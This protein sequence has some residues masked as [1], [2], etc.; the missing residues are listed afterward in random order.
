MIDTKVELPGIEG[1]KLITLESR[2]R[3]YFKRDGCR[4]MS[5]IAR[6]DLTTVECRECG[7][8]NLSPVDWII[9]MIEEWYRI[10]NLILQHKQATAYYEAK[11]RTRCEHCRKI[12]RVAPATSA[13]VRQF[14]ARQKA[15]NDEGSER[16]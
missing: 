8:K 11:Q 14:Q 3:P 7:E 9:K 12:T 4:H 5:I 1:G 15:G 10:E 6:Q 2:G 13:E 16:V